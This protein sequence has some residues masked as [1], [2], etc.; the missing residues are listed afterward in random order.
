LS[1]KKK[2]KKQT[3][4]ALPVTIEPLQRTLCVSKLVFS[5]LSFCFV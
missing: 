2:A 3:N 1:E 4:E 5:P